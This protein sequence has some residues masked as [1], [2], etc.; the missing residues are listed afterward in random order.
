MTQ[1]CSQVTPGFL[2]NPLPAVWQRIFLFPLDRTVRRGFLKV[3]PAH[4][5][6]TPISSAIPKPHNPM[7]VSGICGFTDQQRCS[8][9]THS[10]K[11]VAQRIVLPFIFVPDFNDSYS[12]HR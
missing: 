7:M 11:W 12:T 6:A 3:M 4:L 9:P 1:G 2:K 10:N 8:T 5:K